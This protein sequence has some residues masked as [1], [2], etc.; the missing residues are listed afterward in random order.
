[1]PPAATPEVDADGFLKDLA[2]WSRPVAQ[3]LARHAGIELGADHWRVIELAR[4][5]HARTGVSPA[6]R[7]LVKLARERHGER[8]GSS[9][10]LM[11]LFSGNPAREVAR[12]AGLPRPTDCP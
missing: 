9:I 2:Q 1:M 8:L 10:A 7:P 12:I 5:F 6:M 3:T 11:R 4:D